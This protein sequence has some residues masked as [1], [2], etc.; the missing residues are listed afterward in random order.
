MSPL[1]PRLCGCDRVARSKYWF[2]MLLF[3]LTA[4]TDSVMIY[5]HIGPSHLLTL[6]SVHLIIFWILASSLHLGFFSGVPGLCMY[7]A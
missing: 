5:T 6:Y 2:S 4:S 3:E 7:G 1:D